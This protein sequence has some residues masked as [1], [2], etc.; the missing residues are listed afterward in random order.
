MEQANVFTQ[1]LLISLTFIFLYLSFRFV[2][3]LIRASTVKYDEIQIIKK[4]HLIIRT[5][6]LILNIFVL[7]LWITFI[8]VFS[9]FTL[10]GIL[11]TDINEYFNF[12][13]FAI[14]LMNASFIITVLISLFR[15]IRY[16]TI[17][18]KQKKDTTYYKLL[19]ALDKGD[20]KEIIYNYK[21]LNLNKYNAKADKII[22]T[23]NYWLVL[24][25][26][27]ISEDEIEEA[28]SIAGNKVISGRKIIKHDTPLRKEK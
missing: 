9:N 11:P 25:S 28:K 5:L 23:D 21:L 24:L 14:A 1:I 13:I 12:S 7:I 3:L 18:F 26:T 16:V 19:N 2:L 10:D 20:S 8:K 27:L 22:L 15:L 6:K 4:E 17:F